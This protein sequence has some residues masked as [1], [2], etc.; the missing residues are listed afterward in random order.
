MA[1]P[2]DVKLA[3]APDAAAV[4]EWTDSLGSSSTAPLQ[5]LA[6]Y[7]PAGS[8][9]WQAPTAV[10]SDATQEA[11]EVISLVPVI[12]AN[13]TAAAGVDHLDP[14]LSNQPGYRI[15]V[16]VHP[17]TGAWGAST[18]I[19]PPS[20]TS[21]DLALGMDAEGDLT[22]AFELNVGNPSDPNYTLAVK[23]RPASSGV[24]GSLEDILGLSSGPETVDSSPRLAVSPDG[25]AVIA[26]ELSVPAHQ[27]IAAVNDAEAVTRSGATGSWTSPVDIAPGGSSSTPLADGMSPTDKAYVLYGFLSSTSSGGD[28]IGIVRGTTA[29]AFTN[30]QCVS[31][32]GDNFL[33]VSASSWGALTFLGS[34]AYFAWTGQSSSS[35]TQVPEASRWLDSAAI[36]DSF[37]DLD[38][39]SAE[40]SLDELIPDGN[41]NVV[42]LWTAA[43][44]LRAAAFETAGPNLGSATVPKTG[45]VGQPISMSGSFVDLWSGLSGAPSWEFGDGSTGSGASVSHTF[46]AT[47]KYTITVSADNLL[48]NAT[49]DSYQITI[50]ASTTTKSVTLDDQRIMLTTPSTATCVASSKALSV[51][52]S[53]ATIRNSRRAKLRFSIASFFLDK[54][55]KHSSKTRRKHKTVTVV[56]YRP[57]ATAR[58]V[59]ATLALRLNGLKPGSHTLKVVATYK[60][61]VRKRGHNKTVIVTKTLTSK[62]AVC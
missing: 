32:L 2:T 10:A 14:T 20:D 1:I 48:G 57:N 43:S 54:G 40:A 11:D 17:P 41:G 7:R 19:S 33:L 31:P 38:N 44:G 37:T 9:G 56:T 5:F 52:L 45:F 25:S 8:S 60:E 6:S 55:I 51:K 58:H 12:S 39:P 16:A 49:S 21:P 13:G 30:P 29:G 26:F 28:C 24:W 42:D 62:F 4:V 18:Q 35:G 50:G 15:D 27:S 23:R 3:V 46:N 36:P 47:G 53:S 61:T 59:P 22:A 34:D